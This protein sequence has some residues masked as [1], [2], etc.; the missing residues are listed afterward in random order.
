MQG[1]Q[2]ERKKLEN[3]GVSEG[4]KDAREGKHSAS[5]ESAA[6]VYK[7][8]INRCERPNMTRRLLMFFSIPHPR[9]IRV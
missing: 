2:V 6:K 3:S 8:H 5:A 7:I 4:M 9:M 1:T